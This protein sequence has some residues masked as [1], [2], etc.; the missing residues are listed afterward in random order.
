MLFYI[1]AIIVIIID[2]FTKILV[3]IHVEINERF[4]WWGVEFTHIENSGMAGGLFPGHARVFG[5]VAVLFVL[6][7]MYLRRTEG[8]SGSLID[9]CKWCIVRKQ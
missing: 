6:G 4:T 8:W 1:I 2:Q 7:V 9:S 5:V 3:R